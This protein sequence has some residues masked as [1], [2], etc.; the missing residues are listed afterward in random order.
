MNVSGVTLEGRDR[1]RSVELLPEH[2]LTRADDG[3]DR[4]RRCRG[5]SWI[6]VWPDQRSQPTTWLLPRKA[7]TLRRG[8][9]DFVSPTSI[10]GWR[11]L[12]APTVAERASAPVYLVPNRL[13]VELRMLG[14]LVDREVFVV[15]SRVPGV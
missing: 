1:S 14:D 9:A 8:Q 5:E 7:G 2:A 3:L 6:S 4:P 11:S 15:P 13:R 10:A 12:S